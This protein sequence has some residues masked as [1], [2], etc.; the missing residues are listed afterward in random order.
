ME[1]DKQIEKPIEKPIEKNKKNENYFCYILM[2]SNAFYSNQTYNGSTNDLK[3]RLRQHNGDLV[4]G[5]KSTK[6]KGPWEYLAVL[7]GFKTHKEAL[8]CEW[9]IKHPTG[10]RLR[11]KKYCGVEGRIKSLNLVLNLEKWT[12]NSS[13]LESG[14][15]YV[16][17]VCKEFEHLLEKDKIKT[18]VII[19]KIDELVIK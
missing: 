9:R 3:R 2:T 16:L 8:S 13:G 18:N 15:E 12:N 4:G 1:E 5:A 14:D 10:A 19:K 7:S 6:N 17:Y 11:P